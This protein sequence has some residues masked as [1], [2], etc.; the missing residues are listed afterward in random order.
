MSYFR[1]SARGKSCHPFRQSRP[2]RSVLL[3]VSLLLWG[4]ADGAGQELTGRVQGSVVADDGQPLIDVTISARGASLQGERFARSDARGQFRLLA[5]PPG[6]YKVRFHRIGYRDLALENVPVRLGR[7]TP[8]G[9]VEL[10]ARPLEMAPLVV[11]SGPVVID[12]ITTTLGATLS[13]ETFQT[14][15]TERDYLSVV[16]LL[17][18][19]NQSFFGDELNIS[20]ATGYDNAY[21]IDG[22]NVTEPYRASGATR[23]PYNFIEHIEVKTGGFEAEHGRSMGGIVNV[24]TRSGGNQ[25]RGSVFSYFTS[26]SLNSEG[27]RGLID[28]ESG[29]FTRYDIGLSLGGPI[30]QDRL[31]YFAAYDANVEREELELP[32]DLGPRTDRTLSHQFAGKLTWRA[33]R[34]TDVALTVMG[35]PTTG[36]LVGNVMHASLHPPRAL[37]NPDPF[38]ADMRR[39]GI[40]V[41][42]AATHRWGQDFVLEGSFARSHTRIRTRGA[43]ERGR[44]EMLFMDATTGIWSGGHGN[45]WDHESERTAASVIGSGY[46]G[47]HSVE[48]GIQFEDN[49]LDEEW[50]WQSDGPRGIGHLT[51]LAENS[52][53]GFPLDF[54]TR[55][56]NH[57]VSLF[58]QGSLLFHPRLRLQ[59]GLRW[60][61]QYFRGLTSGLE[62]AITNEI[63]PRLGFIIYPGDPASQKITASYARYYEQLPNLPVSFFYGDLNQEAFLWSHDPRVDASDPLVFNFVFRAVQ[64]LQGQHFDEFTLGYERQ[65]GERMSLGVRGIYR[66]VGEIIA[67]AIVNADTFLAGNPGRGRLDFLP[68]PEHEYTGLELSVSQ[69]GGGDLNFYIAYVLS[70]TAGNYTGLYDQDRPGLSN[71]NAGGNFTDPQSIAAGPLPNDRPHVFKAFGTYRFRWGLRTGLFFTW[72]SGTPLN[73]FGANPLNPTDIV[74]LRPRGDAGRT[75]AIWDLNVRF[76]Y[77]LSRISPLPPGSRLTLDV[78]HAFSP[79]RPVWLEQRRFLAVDPETG[80]QVSL[81]PNYLAPMAFQAPMTLRLGIEIGL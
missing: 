15:P 36:D 47:Q 55:V 75:P 53:L 67:H 35:D 39:G 4:T 22:V 69:Q 57:V 76:A 44:T 13:S 41:S 37:A 56:R 28:L 50:L 80:E 51:K 62:G 1:S 32:G 65:I 6:I 59:P 52:F 33:T 78:L 30:I 17:P 20:G 54:R 8:L 40:T 73:E 70:R 16:T 64:D 42:L 34:G 26:S 31:W 58:A 46:F 43:T 14:L 79:E 72:Q 77:E 68:E 25:F 38:L 60:E 10:E 71:P 3:V 66:T 19:A 18:Q 74:F 63:Q 27:K 24:V 12:P 23:L 5:L 49:V 21:Y 48:A 2:P 11:Q 81:N 7:T 45:E 9:M 29:S 61:G